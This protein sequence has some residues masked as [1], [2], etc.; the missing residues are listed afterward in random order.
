MLSSLRLKLAS[1]ISPEL[2]DQRNNARREA[3]TD[4][5]TGLA[6]RRAFDL[7]LPGANGYSVILFDLENFGQV[8]KLAGHAAGDS[9]LKVFAAVLHLHCPRSFRLGGDEFIALVPNA[10]AFII[11]RDVQ[12]DFGAH[13]YSQDGRR[14]IVAAYGVSA[15]TLAEAD[16]ILSAYKRGKVA[17]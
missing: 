14:A 17:V 3:L 15:A 2:V 5:L 16:H 10:T 4:A 7:A 11:K 1:L 13:Y 12:R 8:N 6:N 9:L